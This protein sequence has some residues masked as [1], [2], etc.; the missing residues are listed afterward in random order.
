MRARPLV[1]RR[2]CQQAEPAQLFV[3]ENHLLVVLVFLQLTKAKPAGK[4]PELLSCHAEQDRCPALVNPLFPP[5]FPVAMA[6]MLL[7][8]RFQNRIP[9]SAR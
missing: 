9:F 2:G 4:P 5:L 1:E 8:P 3:S 6:R 7:V